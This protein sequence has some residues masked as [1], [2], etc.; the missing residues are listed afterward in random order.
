MNLTLA[1]AGIPML[2]VYGPLMLAA[3]L[4]VV[5]VEAGIVKALTGGSYGQW[6]LRVGLANAASTVVGVP[7]TWIALVV[8][9][10]SIG[11]GSAHGLE[12]FW[13]RVYAATVQAPWLIPY[14]DDL[15]WMIGGAGL[16]LSLPF[17]LVSML[18]EYWVLSR[19]TRRNVPEERI[20]FAAVLICNGVTYGF[21]A[22][23]W[24]L[25]LGL[26]LMS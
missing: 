26:G 14:E 11:G 3:L 10:L 24:A 17:F 7:L 19:L 13:Q 5:L 20:G 1:N 9:Q 2:M 6:S 4:P 22:A 21:I 18:I 15:G 16:T 12:T 8:I 23:F 25:M